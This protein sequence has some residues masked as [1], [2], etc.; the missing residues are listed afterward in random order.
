MPKCKHKNCKLLNW[1]MEIGKF[2]LNDLSLKCMDCDGNLTYIP[3]NLKCIKNIPH[4]SKLKCKH[5]Y[6]TRHYH[7]CGFGSSI[8]LQC[9]KYFGPESPHAKLE[10]KEG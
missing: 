1:G 9:G 5:P 3:K 8:C 6:S 10:G 2:C 4:P 7:L